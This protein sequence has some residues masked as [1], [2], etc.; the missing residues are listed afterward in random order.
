[1]Q[2][3]EHAIAILAGL[4]AASILRTAWVRWL[5]VRISGDAAL[6]AVL[7]GTIALALGQLIVHWWPA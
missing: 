1:M 6:I 7:F 4:T 2:S 3:M 5:W